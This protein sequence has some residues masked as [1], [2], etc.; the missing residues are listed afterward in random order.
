ME[1]CPYYE[2][3]DNHRILSS[4]EVT[5]D[6]EDCRSERTEEEGECDGGRDLSLCYPIVSCQTGDRERYNMEIVAV[7]CPACETWNRWLVVLS[8]CIEKLLTD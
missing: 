3:I 2:H 5:S 6:A 1:I 4:P 7:H 8:S